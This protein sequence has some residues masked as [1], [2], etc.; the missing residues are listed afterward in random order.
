M[1][2]DRAVVFERD[3]LHGKRGNIDIFDIFQL[4]L[5]GLGTVKVL[6]ILQYDFG[7]GKLACSCRVMFALGDCLHAVGIV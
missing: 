6:S 7:I 1:L 4:S 3:G 5:L 2:I